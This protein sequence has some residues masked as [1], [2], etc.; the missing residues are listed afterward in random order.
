MVALI[1]GTIGKSFELSIVAKKEN[2][3]A[4]KNDDAGSMFRC[5]KIP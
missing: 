4:G 2:G 1:K 3:D 5:L